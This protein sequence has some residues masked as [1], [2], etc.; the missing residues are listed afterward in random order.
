[1]KNN[2]SNFS[3]KFFTPI[4]ELIKIKKYDEALNKL[5]EFSNQDS[6]IINRFRGSIY[7]NKKDWR[8]SLF[9][10]EK[11]SDESK[12]YKI[13]NNIGVSLYK[14]GKFSEAINAFNKSIDINKKFLSAYENLSITH[15]QL[16]NYDL[17]I[18]FALQTL[19]LAP[20]NKKI[21]NNLI[22]IFNY[23][24]P[25][26]YENPI[27]NLNYQISILDE[28]K[29][30]KL[31]KINLINN[32]LERSER[33]FQEKNISFNYAETQI[34]RRNKIN[35]NC[36]RHFGIFNKYKIIP[37]SCFSC[38]K[39]QINIKNVLDLIKLYFYFNNLNLEKNNI[40]KCMIELREKVL[41][42]YKG[43]LYANSINE[44]QSLKETIKNDLKN[45]K[46]NF[47]KIEIKHG[48]TEYYEQYELYKNIQ[49][50]VTD[51]IYKKKWDNIE[52]DFDKKNFIIEKNEEKVY[53]NTINKFNLS[54][55][56][57]IKNWFIYANIINDYSYK[58]IFKFDI[59]TDHIA[60]IDI[61][62]I[63]MRKTKDD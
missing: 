29:N 55:F 16:G 58:D 37:K 23:Y 49:E 45:Y 30:N 42:N 28:I 35:L 6:D 33:I 52:K 1:M 14:L 11:L 26:S 51:K 47:E 38:Y 5:E 41:G 62:K 27:L 36:D 63:K 19:D 3:E 46:I 40:R 22:E 4:I 9:Y 21:T 53:D 15:K 12:N 17:S 57:I 56:L 32:I 44:V 25:K 59:K 13:L 10:Y 31:I 50:D 20:N 7:L 54:D 18:K 60:K 8:K 43:Y 2:S 61:E 48:C 39:I 34:Y 24:Q